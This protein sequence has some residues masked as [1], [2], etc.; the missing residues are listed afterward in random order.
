M[1][2]KEYLLDNLSEY[3]HVYEDGIIEFMGLGRELYNVLSRHWLAAEVIEIVNNG[4][5]IEV[6]RDRR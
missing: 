1:K 3:I 4:H 6:E 5:N 2:L